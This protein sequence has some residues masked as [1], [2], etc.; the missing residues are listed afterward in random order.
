MIELAGKGAL[1]DT[2][3]FIA[4]MAEAGAWPVAAVALAALLRRSLLPLLARTESAEGFGAKVVFRNELQAI[5]EAVESEVL[6]GRQ[7]D[8]SR[9]VD[10]PSPGK[11]SLPAPATDSL[12]QNDEFLRLSDELS[13]TSS[14][15]TIIAGWQ[16]VESALRHAATLVGID[17]D[18]GAPVNL[19]RRMQSTGVLNDDT[20]RAVERLRDL[21]NKVVHAR[22]PPPPL[23]EARDYRETAG[24][25]SGI[26]AID[27]AAWKRSVPRMPA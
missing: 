2:Y 17:S 20:V 16:T 8:P 19:I 23:A 6:I 10:E 22:I 1:M 11:L 7:N 3:Q 9:S 14:I 5:T 21:R 4:A 12:Q 13:H 18:H 25:L 15:G 24:T 26:I 27:V